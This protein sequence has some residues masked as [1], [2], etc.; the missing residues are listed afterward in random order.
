MCQS[1]EPT[2][3]REIRKVNQGLRPSADRQRLTPIKSLANPRDDAHI[4]RSFFLRP[5]LIPT[6]VFLAEL[7]A[8]VSIRRRFDRYLRFGAQSA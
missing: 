6:V 7:P 4:T 3:P 1:E 2:Q 8:G 5:W